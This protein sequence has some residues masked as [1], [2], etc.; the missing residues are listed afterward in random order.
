MRY[1]VVLFTQLLLSFI[2]RTCH[3]RHLIHKNGLTILQLLVTISMH[4]SHKA[5]AL[6]LQAETR[7]GSKR[8][9]H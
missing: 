8:F 2:H 9:L 1:V 6:S 4:K 3:L 7:R 5:T